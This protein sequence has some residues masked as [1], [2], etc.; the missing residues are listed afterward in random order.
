MERQAE[1]RVTRH[2]VTVCELQIDSM[3]GYMM[4]GVDKGPHHEDMMT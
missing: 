1:K 3:S 4:V 2:V